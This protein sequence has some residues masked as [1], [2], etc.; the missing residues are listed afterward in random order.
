MLDSS[1]IW[2]CTR[3][4]R[5]AVVDNTDKIVDYYASWE[6][7][8]GEET[9]LKGTARSLSCVFQKLSGKLDVAGM[10]CKVH[11]EYVTKTRS[12]LMTPIL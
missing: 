6:L 4:K 12:C 10:N 1:R 7:G 2:I 5:H 3:E 11:E 9:A 8:W